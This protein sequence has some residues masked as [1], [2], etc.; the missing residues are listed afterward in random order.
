MPTLRIQKFLSD[1]GTTVSELSLLTEI[2]EKTLE[3]YAQEGVEINPT[4]AKHLRKIASKLDIPPAKLIE[5]VKKEVGRH[6]KIL[7]ALESSQHQGLSFNRLSELAKV[8]PSMLLLYSTQVLLGKKWEEPQTQTDVSAIASA[9]GTSVEDLIVLKDPPTTG[10]RVS[11]FL[12]EK[13]LTIQ[14]FSLINDIPESAVNFIA[15]E[16]IDL[17]EL[18]ETSL[19]PLH[20]GTACVCCHI[21]GRPR[22]CQNC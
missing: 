1:R 10:V 9:L 2:E 6:L 17:V 16:P 5:P 19:S 4:T 21:M 18:E 14:E 8:H 11:D 7:K 15:S 22:C 20:Q 12:E 13:G 3:R